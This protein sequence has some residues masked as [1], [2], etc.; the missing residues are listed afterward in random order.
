M[1]K[2]EFHNTTI[3]GL[4]EITPFSNSDTRGEF[5]KDYSEKIFKE[6]GIEHSL[7]EI[8]YSTSCTGTLRG[9]HIQTGKCQAKLVRCIYGH[10]YDVVAD[11]RPQSATFKKWLAFDLTGDNKKEL[12]VPVGC[13]HGFLALE[14]SMVSYKCSENFYPEYDSGVVWDDTDLNIDWK[15]ERIGGAQNLIIT[16]KD[17]KLFASADFI[18]KFAD[19]YKNL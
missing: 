7:L 2:F 3:E 9:L 12:L 16:D 19:L 6:N 14:Q 13:A 10:I 1:Q 5:I 4:I 17:K 18:C 15:L 8:F 11:L